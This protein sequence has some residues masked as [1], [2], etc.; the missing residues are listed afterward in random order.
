VSNAVN[1]QNLILPAGTAKIGTQEYPVLINSSTSLVDQLNMLPLK[2]YGSSTVM[3][4]DVAHVSDKYM[5]QTNLVHVDGKKG[6]LEAIYKLGGA[7][8]LDIVDR[9]KKQLPGILSRVPENKQ[10]KVTPLFDQSIFV[11]AAVVGVVKEAAIAAGLTGL[12]I[13]LFLGSWRST[14]IICV[15]IPLSILVSIICLW[16]L[17]ETLN[18]MTLGGMA[19]AVGILVDEATVEIENIHR[20]LHQRKRLVKAIL[21]GAQQIAVPA[22]VS[23]LCICIVFVPVWFIT[24]AAKSLFTPLAMGVIFAMLTSYLLSRTLVPTLVHYL[25][26]NEVEMYGGVEQEGVKH[27]HAGPT[28]VHIGKSIIWALCAIGIVVAAIGI[29]VGIAWVALYFMQQTALFSASM[30]GFITEL[31]AAFRENRFGTIKPF[32]LWFLLILLAVSVIHYILLNNWIWRSHEAFNVHF[33]RF[34]KFYGGFL[35]FALHHRISVLAVF[36]VF[37]I[38]SCVLF[39]YVGQD[40]FPAVDA[41][42]IRLH[43]RAPAGTRLEESELKFADV[44]AFIRRQIPPEQIDTVID[45]IGIPNSGI[46]M[47]LSDGSQI[48][49]ADGEILISLKENHQPTA[50]LVK[51]LRKALPGEF[52]QMGFWFQAADI[53]TQVLNFGLPAPIDVQIIGSKAN[54]EKNYDIALELRKQIAAIPGAVDVHVHQ[55][56]R[57]PDLDINVDRTMASQIGVTQQAV[58]TDVLISLSSSNTLAPNYWLDP[59]RGIQYAVGLMTPQF[60][61]G[62]IN[63]LQ[64][65]PITTPAT[66]SCQ[67]STCRPMCRTP[68]W[69]RSPKRFRN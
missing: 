43:V 68:I 34:R 13:L 67:P 11:R 38:G 31:P 50:S 44:E 19:L 42:Q 55:V 24:G 4:K 61:T 2:S 16:V 14:V 27:V 6:V 7:S 1:N 18:V 62:T 53:A 49:S 57:T 58:A 10:F 17:G 8:T 33:E 37:V 41:G 32:I 56:M 64:N 12:M 52:P 51:K 54:L 3:I 5:P 45:N 47:S 21:D 59:K 20:N 23:T 66:I 9:I 40:F 46:N 28:H 25:L 15:S 69:A 36:V 22:F 30:P 39:P 35:G 48:S 60:E 65:T 29:L 26:E 63:A